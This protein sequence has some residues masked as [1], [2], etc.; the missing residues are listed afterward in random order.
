MICLGYL[1]NIITKVKTTV[2]SFRVTIGKI[3][4][5]FT[6]SSGHI[7]GEHCYNFSNKLDHSRTRIFLSCRYSG[8]V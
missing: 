2:A 3:G 7:A 6:P 8:Q 5:L 4:L 1:K